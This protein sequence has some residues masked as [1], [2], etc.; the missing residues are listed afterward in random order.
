MKILT[1]ILTL[2]ISLF[3]FNLPAAELG[4][5]ALIAGL[6][7]DPEAFEKIHTDKAGGI[8]PFELELGKSTV[9][10]SDE[11]VLDGFR[12]TVPDDAQSKDLIWYFNA[13]KAWG[14]WYICPVEGEAG[15]GFQNWFYGDKVYQPFDLDG[16]KNRLRVLQ[17][18]SGE[19]LE[20]GRSYILWFRRVQGTS[21][22]KL[23]GCIGFAK[24]DDD[25]D[26]NS[27]E[28]ALELK[29]KGALS[30][31]AQLNSR[32][33]KILLDRSFFRPSYAEGRI[34]SVFASLRNTRQMRGG[35]FFTMEVAVPPCETEPAYEKIRRKFGA[36]DFVQSG[37]EL[38]RLRKSWTDEVDDSIDQGVTT[39]YY[40]YFGFEVRNDDDK[41]VVVRVVSHANDYSKLHEKK[42]ER[43]FGQVPMK[44][45]TAF[46]HKGKEVGRMY[47]FLEGGKEPFIIQEPPA[48]K[49]KR[50]DEV[51]EYK[52]KGEWLSTSFYDDGPVSRRIP[53][54]R[55][56][57]T[58][59]AEG[60]HLNGKT[61]FVAFYKKGVL[62]GEVVEYSEDGKVTKRIEFKEGRRVEDEN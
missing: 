1:I 18:L 53:Y 58:G 46:H 19:N 51:L 50:G 24:N 15:K 47:Y 22:G 8:V 13:P 27:I 12:F 7:G 60:F 49:Y 9:T 54:S 10:I 30:Q 42:S 32:G 31:V 2:L 37:K 57:M 25:W 38:V 21:G 23:R 45:L 43:S 6:Q 29:T 4:P 55:N 41:E 16:E 5:E 17:T 26:H 59:K 48:G 61:S 39:Y 52:G 14:N 35:M 56:R 11:F 33:G 36:A 40:D 28:K 62:D 44:N 34:D 20:A 3:L